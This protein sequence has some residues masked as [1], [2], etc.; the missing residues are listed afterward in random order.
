M[1]RRAFLAGLALAPSAAWAANDCDRW[2]EE[3][4]GLRIHLYGD[5]ISR[6]FAL[7][8]FADEIAPSH[9]LYP[10]R[11][12]AAMMNGVMEESGLKHVAAYMGDAVTPHFD[13]PARIRQRIKQGAIRPGDFVV[14]EDA[15]N[16]GSDPDAYYVKMAA[17][18]QA[19]TEEHGITCVMMTMFDYPPAPAG[20]QYDLAFNGKTHNAATR[21]AA[22]ET[23]P[24]VG[25]TILVEMDA[26][27]D[28]RRSYQMGH[29]GTDV[30][31]GDGIHPNVWG[32]ALIAGEVLKAAGLRQ[33]IGSV[34]NAI[35][36]AAPHWDFLRYGSP[37]WTA[38]T[39]PVFV[40]DYLR[41]CLLR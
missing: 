9:P 29:T 34:E 33:I 31:L 3:I 39:G 28:A 8:V 26:I 38:E 37:Y 32:Q 12:P 21:Q 24:Y 17:L 13:I 30:V 27:M 23:K 16:H 41:A 5:S 2:C 40:Q 25:Q 20:Y 18:R 11:S 6:G 7:G 15:G 36:L 4:T 14:I 1:N 35:A 22:T 10:F 19:V